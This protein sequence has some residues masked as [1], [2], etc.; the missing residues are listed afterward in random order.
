MSNIVV[1]LKEEI[2]RLA[3]KE[4]RAMV[5]STKRAVAKYRREI[6]NLKKLLGDQE[7]KVAVLKKQLGEQTGAVV[8]TDDTPDIRFSPRSIKAQRRRLKLSAADYGLLVGV[9]ALTIYHWEA[10]KSRPRK[11]QLVS[12]A[13]VRGIGKREALARLDSLKAAHKHAK[14]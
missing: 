13:A 5:G 6:T 3:R 14:K 8:E 7:K 4:I 9:S 12:L 11:A 1:A 10:G 2:R